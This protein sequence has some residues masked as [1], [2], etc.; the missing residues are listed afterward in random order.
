ML[1]PALS[2]AIIKI[3]NDLCK[4][5]DD[6]GEFFVYGLFIDKPDKK[7]FP[8]YYQFIANPIAIK[9]MITF[10]KKGKYGSVTDVQNDMELLCRNAEQYNQEGSVVH[11]A[12]LALRDDFFQQL[13][14]VQQEFASKAAGGEERDGQPELK[15]KRGGNKVKASSSSS[16]SSDLGLKMT[17]PSSLFKSQHQR[18][19]ESQAQNYSVDPLAPNHNNRSSTNTSTSASSK[20]TKKLKI[21]M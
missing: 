17:L 2:K 16:S 6:T 20:P 1:D 4:K 11:N 9:S 3:L 15:R 18:Q 14:E 7:L 5:L 13:D 10:L 21:V 8:D 19:L 12:S